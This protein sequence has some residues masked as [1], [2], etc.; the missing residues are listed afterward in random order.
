MVEGLR[1]APMCI[2]D[3][4]ETYGFSPVGFRFLSIYLCFG[5]MGW[6]VCRERMEGFAHA[7]HYAF[8]PLAPSEHWYFSFSSFVIFVYSLYI[9][10]AALPSP[11]STLLTYCLPTF[12]SPSPLRR[13]GLPWVPTH[14]GISSHCRTRHIL[15]RIGQARQPVRWNRIHR[16]ATESGTN[17]LP[18]VGGHAWRPA[19]YILIKH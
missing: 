4:R 16:Q 6:G 3:P 2:T 8:S 5:G 17:P 13:G 18:V 1:R 14:P 12:L 9:P 19:T 15:S 11:P 10:I 7:T